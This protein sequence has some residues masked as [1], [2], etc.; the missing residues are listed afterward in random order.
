MTNYID[1]IRLLPLLLSSPS[2]AQ[3]LSTLSLP[4]SLLSLPLTLFGAAALV[5]AIKSN[6]KGED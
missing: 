1:L 3:A 4:L 6:G 5:R 2:L